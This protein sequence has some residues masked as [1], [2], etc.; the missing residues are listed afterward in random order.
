[1]ASSCLQTMDAIREQG[2]DEDAVRSV[3]GIMHLGGA[4]TVSMVNRHSDL[5]DPEIAHRPTAC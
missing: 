4:D 1:M 2:L 3:I 5:H